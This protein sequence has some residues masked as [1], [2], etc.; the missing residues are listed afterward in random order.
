MG[1]NGSVERARKF[2][3]CRRPAFTS[4]PGRK[5]IGNSGQP[6][7][8]SREG[9]DSSRRRRRLPWSWHRRGGR[10]IDRGPSKRF[11]ACAADCPPARVTPPRCFGSCRA[12][13][14][15]RFA[16][17]LLIGSEGVGVF[18]L[19]ELLVLGGGSRRW[20][21]RG[22]LILELKVGLQE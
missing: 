20:R 1:A 15:R 21:G 13:P 14:S 7:R 16:G 4:R 10:P 22:D 12:D 18:G 8:D 17:T 3:G 5:I 2:R 9:R 19:R 11:L 6:S